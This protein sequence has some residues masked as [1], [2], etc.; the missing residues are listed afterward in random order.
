MHHDIDMSW[1]SYVMAETQHDTDRNSQYALYL[2][3]KYLLQC[4]TN[5]HQIL[6]SIIIQQYTFLP[7]PNKQNLILA[8]RSVVEVFL[9]YYFIVRT[10]V[11]WSYLL[12]GPKLPS[13]HIWATHVTR[14]FDIWVTLLLIPRNPVSMVSKYAN[15]VM[16]VVKSELIWLPERG[17]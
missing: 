13:S 3:I 15:F 4:T 11:L 8:D 9:S 12:I 16:A 7:L 1:E 2:S 10:C 6:V 17:G 14:D 5:W